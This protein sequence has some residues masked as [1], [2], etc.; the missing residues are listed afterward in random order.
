[1]LGRSTTRRVATAMV[2]AGMSALGC[3]AAAQAATPSAAPRVVVATCTTGQVVSWLN[4]SGNG[5]AGGIGYELEFTNVSAH[6][7]TLYGFPGVS[8]VTRAGHQLGGA[9][10]RN[11][12]RTRAVVVKPGRTARALLQVTFT[13]N[14]TPSACK[15]VTAFGLR[16]YAAGAFGSDVIP[17]PFSVCSTPHPISI[18]VQSTTS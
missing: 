3:A 11:G 13:G 5:Y 1:M 8:A 4:T 10:T 12:P 6:A 14:F 7:C 9:A 16:V 2:V 17:F 15:P 18:S